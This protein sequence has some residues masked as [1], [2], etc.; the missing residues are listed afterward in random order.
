MLVVVSIIKLEH[1]I[2]CLYPF[3]FSFGV[4]VAG[5]NP[6]A[7]QVENGKKNV[8]WELATPRRL[9]PLVFFAVSFW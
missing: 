7:N 6:G 5:F 1:L 3:T 4:V 2:C 9:H 8:I